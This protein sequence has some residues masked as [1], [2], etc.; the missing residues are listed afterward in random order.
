MASPSYDE[1]RDPE[2]HTFPARISHWRMVFDP[3]HCTPTVQSH[4]YDGEGT[5]ESPFIV[6]WLDSDPRNPYNWSVTKRALITCCISASSLAAS[7]SSSAYTGSSRQVERHFHVGTEVATL[8]LSLFVLGFAV[9]PILFAPL[10]ELYG[11][12]PVFISTYGAL[13]VFNAGAAGAK[14]IQ[15]LLVL[16]F[17]AGV[18]GS[19]PL[20]NA[21]GQI[22]DMFGPRLVGL[23]MSLFVVAPFIGPALGPIIGGYIGETVGWRW[24]ERFLAAFTGAIWLLGVLFIPETYAPVLLR[25]R[26]QSLSRN[27]KRRHVS[28]RSLQTFS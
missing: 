9:G 27:R 17:F 6:S 21:G 23:A 18:F 1:K 12:Q 20:T 7:L 14:N 22:S 2:D 13:A 26:A 8:G 25:K 19:S 16:R 10:S 24:V 15:T 5:K 11:R 28:K 3:G 4:C